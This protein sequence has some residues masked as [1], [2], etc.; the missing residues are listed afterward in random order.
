MSFGK[1]VERQ[2]LG[3][4]KKK[5]LHLENYPEK[6]RNELM[7]ALN[8]NAYLPYQKSMDLV[9][10]MQHSETPGA[11]PTLFAKDLYVAVARKLKIKEL[12]ELRYFTAV[13]SP[14]DKYHGVDAFF[15]YLDKENNKLIQATLDITT[16]P[17]KGEDYKADVIMLVPGDGIDSKVDKKEYLEYINKFAPEIAQVILERKEY[18]RY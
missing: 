14:L 7:A 5:N 18:G 6:K 1:I 2:M 9:K 8:E 13:N 16:N 11:L 4:T 17:E 10:K 15:E 12:A 3:E